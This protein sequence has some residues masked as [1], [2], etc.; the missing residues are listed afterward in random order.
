MPFDYDG[1]PE[2]FYHHVT[3]SGH[4]VR[5]AWHLQKFER[6]RECLPL[7]AGQ[8]VL[9][10]GCFSGTFLSMLDTE[11]FTHQVGVDIL[12]KQIAFAGKHFGHPHRRFLFLRNLAALSEL[13][14]PFDVITVIEVIEHLTK[15][16]I[17]ALLTQA[18]RLLASGGKLVLSTPNY[19]ST[20]P[21][22]ERIVDRVSEVA[23][24]EQHITKFTSFGAHRKLMQIAPELR[25]TLA[26]DFSTTTHFL[27]PFLAPLGLEFS[28]KVSRVV[29]HQHWGNPFGNLVLMRYSKR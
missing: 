13:K 6:V 4:P 18:A 2:G 29:P 25:E 21:L 16:E 14:G 12:E 20:W 19:A 26:L 5:R 10:I 7:R 17:H 3:E 28:M 24:E 11:W 15:E 8:S 23:Y 9:D 27:A 1:I 22:L